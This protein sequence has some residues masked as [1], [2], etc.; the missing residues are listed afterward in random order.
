MTF[1]FRLG[2]IHLWCSSLECTR[3][4]VEN[5]ARLVNPA[6]AEHLRRIMESGA[7]V[8]EDHPDHG[9]AASPLK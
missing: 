9:P 5:G 4:L 3:K 6:Q 2:D 7:S 8:P 1:E